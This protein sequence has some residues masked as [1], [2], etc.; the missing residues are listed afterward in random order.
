MRVKQQLDKVLEMSKPIEEM[1]RSLICDYV[2]DLDAYVA[3]CNNLL[4][5]G[6]GLPNEMLDDIIINIPAMLYSVGTQRER[7]IANMN[8]AKINLR[9]EMS[10]YKLAA[11]GTVS[12]RQSQAEL[13]CEDEEVAKLIMETAVGLIKAREECAIELLQSAKKIMSRRTEEIK[14]TVAGGGATRA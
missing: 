13:S 9:N 3:D 6:D 12:D 8:I 4:L 1:A 14:L 5:R 10:K 11:E 2:D 7:L